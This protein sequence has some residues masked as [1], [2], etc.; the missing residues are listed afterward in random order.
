MRCIYITPFQLDVGSVQAAI[1][2]KSRMMPRSTIKNKQ[3]TRAFVRRGLLQ[4]PEIRGVD[5]RALPPQR[6]LGALRSTG[7]TFTLSI[8]LQFCPMKHRNTC[9]NGRALRVSKV[10]KTRVF[11]ELSKIFSLYATSEIF[12]SK[13]FL[14]YIFG[15]I[16][17]QRDICLFHRVIQG[18]LCKMAEMMGNH[19]TDHRS[20]GPQLTRKYSLKAIFSMLKSSEWPNYL[21]LQHNHL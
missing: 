2:P 20:H 19:C 4:S 17:P 14:C 9:I 7:K 3:A 13:L 16:A 12:K 5:N 8:W 1:L 15:Y 10:A 6:G 18:S 11:W 21:F